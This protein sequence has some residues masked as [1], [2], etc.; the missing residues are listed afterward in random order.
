[1]AGI[2]S[3]QKWSVSEM[4]DQTTRSVTPVTSLH[5]GMQR[6]M[7]WCQLILLARLSFTHVA[8]SDMQRLIFEIAATVQTLFSLFIIEKVS[9]QVVPQGS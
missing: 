6:E 1:M 4:Q 3:D 9:G 2:F 8:Q 7:K 5:V